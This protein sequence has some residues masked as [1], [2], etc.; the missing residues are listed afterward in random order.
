MTFPGDGKPK[1]VAF[2]DP[3]TAALRGARVA[4]LPLP[5]LVELKLASGMTAPHRLKDLADVQELIRIQRLPRTFVLELN[6]FVRDKYLELWQPWIIRRVG[7]PPASPPSC[8]GRTRVDLL[9]DVEGWPK[10]Y[11][12]CRWVEPSGSAPSDGRAPEGLSF[13]WKARPVVWRTVV[14]AVR[15]HT[16]AIVAMPRGSTP[17]ARSRSAP[18]P[19]V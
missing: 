9:A 18:R 17:T 1:P 13:R 2:P 14:A 6:A 12:A 19:T 5:T 15:P 10:W 3:A 16:F 11:R 7:G 4:L 8:L